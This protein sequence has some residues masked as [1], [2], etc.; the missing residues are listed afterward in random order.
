MTGVALRRAGAVDGVQAG[1]PRLHAALD[2][3][4]PQLCLVA[5]LR[6]VDPAAQHR[7][8][9]DRAVDRGQLALQG[10]RRRELPRGQ[11]LI[12]LERDARSRRHVAVARSRTRD[13]EALAV[14]RVDVPLAT[15]P[16]RHL[17]AHR[18]VVALRPF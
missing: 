10:L 18:E 11:A 16:A 9:M 13:L 2:L 8:R 17:V 14:A 6:T 3:L 4:T 5:A 7:D 1:P 15:A 12:G